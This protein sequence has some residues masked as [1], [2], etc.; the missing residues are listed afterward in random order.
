[1]PRDSAP[2]PLRHAIALGLTQGPTELLPVSSSAHTSL[3][4]WL[5]RWSYTE[6]APESRK[7]F[8]VALH[9]GAG[10][11][12][13]IAMRDEPVVE[14]ANG[15]RR[16]GAVLKALSLLPPVLAGQLL[17]APIERRLGG[18]RTIAAGLGAGAVAMALADRGPA[19]GR[20]RIA[21]AVPADGLALGGA[22]ALA[23]FPGVSRSGATLAAAR[24]RGFGRA[25]AQALSWQAALPVILG[26]SLREA[27]RISDRGAPAGMR[28]PLAAGGTAA[29]ASTFL[30]AK[31]LAGGRRRGRALLPYAIYR[32]LLAI[33][34]LR[35]VRSAHNRNG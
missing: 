9:A 25:D 32:C 34:V 16:R 3:I 8:E 14:V 18:P 22:Q 10:L 30:S 31:L 11:A 28:A 12:L 15:D 6:L 24:A 35:R 26:A 23:L 21:E 33:L 20:R 5:G 29:F 19:E 13:A 1:M 17:R 2:L 27:L 7:A 4:P